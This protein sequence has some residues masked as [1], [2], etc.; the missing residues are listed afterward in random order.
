M[1]IVS[2]S[3]A[4]T[5]KEKEI[6]I[7]SQYYFANYYSGEPHL[8]WTKIHKSECVKG[9]SNMEY[10]A[11]TLR[12]VQEYFREEHNIHINPV[13]NATTGG[14]GVELLKREQYGKECTFV[15]FGFKQPFTDSY[16]WALEQ[17]ILEALKLV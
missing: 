16:D 15:G 5:L 10:P 6:V 3:T 7:P 17:G 11:P 13:F 9:F 12:D 14:Y 1:K 4:K 2:I 8:K